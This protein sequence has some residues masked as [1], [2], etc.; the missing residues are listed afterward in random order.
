MAGIY[1][2]TSRMSKPENVLISGFSALVI[3]NMEAPARTSIIDPEGVRSIKGLATTAAAD[4][5][6]VRPDFT[7]AIVAGVAAN[8]AV[9]KCRHGVIVVVFVD[10]L[11]GRTH[12]GCHE[13][14]ERD[15]VLHDER[16]YGDPNS[17]SGGDEVNWYD[18]PMNS[19]AFGLELD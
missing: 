2:I 16:R 18:G 1:V 15:G 7:I 10:D 13:C 6:I 4:H 12:G 11:D 17:D 5:K 3:D 9:G 8:D 19:F 14:E